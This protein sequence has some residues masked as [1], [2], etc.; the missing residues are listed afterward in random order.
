MG[1]ERIQARGGF[2]LMLALLLLCLPL[3]WFLAA[4]A[5][6]A[7]HECGH[8]LAIFCYRRKQLA[9][10]FSAFSAK[11]PLPEMGTGAELLCA[12]AGP[13]AGLLLLFAARWLPRMA[14]CALTQSA[15]N[16]LPIYPLDGGRVLRC[17]LAVCV[18]PPK[19]EK[20][21]NAAA[22][23]TRILLA[24]AAVYAAFFLDLGLL[25]LLLAAVLLFRL[26]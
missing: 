1:N 24:G 22:T 9:I 2:F 18:P 14:L 5:A 16:L 6:A 19:A 23:V 13:M 15:F 10:S 20:I 4:A 17:A 7:V 21:C 12:L 25:P 3:P 26:K 8:L 11:I